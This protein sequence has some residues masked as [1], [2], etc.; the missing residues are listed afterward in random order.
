MR[1]LDFVLR[2]GA[3]HRLALGL[4][5]GTAIFFVLRGHLR[6]SS[7]AIAAWDAFAVLILALDWLTILMTPQ[8]KICDLARQQDLSRLLVFLFVVVAACAALFAVG[9]LIVCT[10]VRLAG[11]S[12]FIYCSHFWQ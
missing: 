4:A 7:A 3:R 10:R 11:I 9:F 5:A 6:F 8:R 1:I 2:L 12:P